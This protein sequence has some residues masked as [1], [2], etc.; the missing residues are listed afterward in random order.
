MIGDARDDV[1]EPGL[2]VDAVE[3]GGLDQGVEDGGAPAAGVGTGEEIVLSSERQS[4][5]ARSAAL[6]EIS[7]RPSARK[8]VSAAQRDVA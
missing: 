5:M 8:R 1:G 4:R 7:R 2:G 3:A 6:F